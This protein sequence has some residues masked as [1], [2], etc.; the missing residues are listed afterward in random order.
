MI[1]HEQ[2]KSNQ[3]LGLCIFTAYYQLLHFMIEFFYPDIHPSPIKTIFEGFFFVK[4]THF[5]K[6]NVD[7]FFVLTFL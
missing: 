6:N 5:Q 2:I 4:L 1:L 3:M 7:I